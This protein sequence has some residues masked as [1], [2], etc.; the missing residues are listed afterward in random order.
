MGAEFGSG[1]NGGVGKFPEPEFGDLDPLQKSVSKEWNSTHPPA[2]TLHGDV[3]SGGH[4]SKR[5]H[6]STVPKDL[7]TIY[8]YILFWGQMS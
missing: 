6:L 7:Y 2:P 1:A 3:G 8:L 5:S 4:V